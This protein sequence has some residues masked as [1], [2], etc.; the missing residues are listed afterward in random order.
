MKIKKRNRTTKEFIAEVQEIIVMS[1]RRI[2]RDKF[3]ENFKILL[4]QTNQTKKNEK[5]IIS[6]SSTI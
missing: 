2:L 4:I 1:I 6:K 5:N 3:Y